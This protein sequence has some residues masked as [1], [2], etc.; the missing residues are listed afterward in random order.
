MDETAH[1]EKPQDPHKQYCNDIAPI[2]P[3]KKKTGLWAWGLLL[4][5]VPL[6]LFAGWKS[7]HAKNDQSP[8][9]E[10]KGEEFTPG[11]RR[12]Q[13]A[14]VR[15]RKEQEQQAALLPMR[16]EERVR[17]TS[18][19]TERD[20]ALAKALA[21]REARRHAP[22]VVYGDDK[23]GGA[24]DP[25]ELQEREQRS[26]GGVDVS[27]L[28]FPPGMFDGRDARVSGVSGIPG[29]PNDAWMESRSN[30]S[31]LQVS[32]ATA[33]RSDECRITEGKVISAYLQTPI[34]STLPGT[35]TAR[36]NEDV[37]GGGR[38]PLIP[39]MSLLVGKYNANL[40]AGQQVIGALWERVRM[41]DGSWV[42]I[43]S[44]GTDAM[45]RTGYGG[46]T[47]NFFLER[48]AIAGLVSLIGVGSSTVGAHTSDQYNSIS[49]YRTAVSDAAGRTANSVL[50]KQ[51]NIPQ[52]VSVPHGKLISVMVVNRD[53]EFPERCVPQS[54]S[55]EPAEVW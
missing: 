37:Y 15:V 17:E 42:Q 19:H 50:E 18:D 30:G 7:D 16:Q 3:E 35:I 31:A 49:A 40:G 54:G 44:P 45:G 24:R 26:R 8:K 53:L 1:N 6:I 51:G 36:V 13:A 22:M 20:Q 12:P 23:N 10:G 5:S 38:I 39:A 4:L 21:E 43:N 32:R 29:D 41:P 48:F 55:A 27:R 28:Q 2:V 33:G 11:E 46:D 34:V 47:E 52:R 25:R 9:V 14:I